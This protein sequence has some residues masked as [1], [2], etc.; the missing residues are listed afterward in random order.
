MHGEA[1]YFLKISKT[2]VLFYCFSKNSVIMVY[3]FR[4]NRGVATEMW[5]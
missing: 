5:I 1:F 2:V 4:N 3:V